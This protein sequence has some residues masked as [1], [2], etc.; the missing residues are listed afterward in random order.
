MVFSRRKNEETP[1][2]SNADEVDYDDATKNR[3]RSLADKG[4]SIYAD[5]DR[6]DVEARIRRTWYGAKKEGSQTD[7]PQDQGSSP[8]H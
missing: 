7:G 1:V 8:G 6:T 2:R 4:G 3:L 5:G